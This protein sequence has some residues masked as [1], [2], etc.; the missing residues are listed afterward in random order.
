MPQ[1][2]VSPS[3]PALRQIQAL[4]G[5]QAAHSHFARPT[6]GKSRIT[7]GDNM[8]SSSRNMSAQ[9][10]CNAQYCSRAA[11]DIALVAAAFTPAFA[12]AFAPALSR[13]PPPPAPA[14]AA[15]VMSDQPSQSSP[16]SDPD[17]ISAAPNRIRYADDVEA[18]RRRSLRRRASN[19]SDLS[20]R[21]SRSFARR[22]VEPAVVLPIEFRTLSF[23]V[24]QT[25]A[26]A[27]EDLELKE[28]EKAKSP[29]KKLDA[30]FDYATVDWHKLTVHDLCIRLSTSLQ[31]GLSADVAARKLKEYG[32]NAPSPPPS[33]WFRRSVGYF[34]GGFG[35][36]LLTASILVFIAWKPLGD[37]PAQAN[38]ALA[39]VLLVVFFINAAFNLYQDWSSSRV[40]SSIKTM[41]PEECLLLRDGIKQHHQGVDIVPGDVLYLRMGDKLPA[42]VRFVE[43]S[44]DAKF[45]RSI[46]TGETAP[47][48]GTVDS[49]DENFLETACIGMAGTHIVSGS[50]VGVVIGTGDHSV[51]G[52]LAKLT[53]APKT[54]LTGLEK[55]IYYFVAMIVCIM[56]T[57]VIIVISVWAGW[58]RRDHPHWIN[59]SQLIVD[60]VSVAVAFIPEGLPIAVTASLTIVAS[61]MRKNAIL[62]KS[63]KT[64]ETL[65]SVSV[66]CSDKT[67]TLTKNQMRVT[68][69]LVGRDVLTATEAAGKVQ[70][71][72]VS[73]N[74][75]EPSL[76]CKQ[77]AVVGSVCNAGEFDASTMNKP[78]SERKINGDATDTAVLRFSEGLL[79]VHETRQKWRN[80]YR[81]AFNSKNKFMIQVAQRDVY[82]PANDALFDNDN[83]R[84]EDQVLMIK[85]APDILLPRCT[86]FMDYEGHA[87]PLTESDRCFLE[88][89][90]NVY[91][92]QGKRVILLAQKVLPKHVSGISNESA[93]YENAI[94]D[95]ASR[96]FLLIGLVA[97]VDPP[98]DEIPEVVK[99]LRGAGIKIFMVT[100]DF[101]LT[102][103]AIAADCG[104]ITNP[105][106]DIHDIHSLS[107]E[108][109]SPPDEKSVEISIPTST[110]LGAPRSLVISGGDMNALTHEQWDALCKYD[111]IVFARTTPE[112]KLKIVMELQARHETVGMTGDGVNDAPSL[113]QADIGIAMG[114]GSDIAI[115]AADMVLLESFAAVVEAVK[116]GRVVF[117]NL[118]KTICYLIPAGTFSEFW[119]IMTN[120]LFGLPQV[121]SS[122]LMIIICCFTDCAAATAIAYEKPEADV[123]RQRPR[124]PRKDRLVDWKLMLHAYGTIGVMQSVSSFAMAYWYC[125]R[126]GLPFSTLWFGFGAVPEGMSQER[127]QQILNHASSIYFVNLV[128]MQWFNLMAV[129][130]RRLSLLQHPPLWVKETRNLWLFPAILFS[131][132]IAFLFLYPKQLQEVLSTTSVPVAHWFL[133]MAF[134][135][136]ILLLDEA[137]KWAARKWPRGWVA[138][139]AW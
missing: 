84:P 113:K 98:R 30:E 123:L 17:L 66:I 4:C 5:G 27:V 115:E 107:T 106:E 137:R 99:T 35:S 110:A 53:S 88:D 132:G 57:M 15:A 45:D 40:M 96:G 65:G 90:K 101:Q 44:P 67:G 129:R 97:I 85:G 36:I 63:L 59:V 133:P 9:S 42:D 26:K 92:K 103:A 20:T 108:Y 71:S 7:G 89:A 128:V 72:R 37:P 117:D 122:F 83:P 64:V 16:D 80:V 32:P 91:S 136:G 38:L 46:L 51:F 118:K 41:L 126:Q 79:S 70:L 47:L 25:Q 139:V 105:P 43:V 48:R 61:I 73:A 111:E 6:T 52:R 60:C 124:N 54:G 78:L 12:P 127:S 8:A 130:T 13:H 100:G 21:T 3:M 2:A 49:T 112:Q 55:E 18:L 125:Q 134:G 28:K 104:I 93:Q 33:T 31:H 131:L 62:C 77:L 87:Q 23:N 75:A 69:C 58:L 121:L 34:F 19:A 116:Y 14:R 74:I 109:A 135:M 10:E 82:E 94:M 120:V 114:G 22:E 86:R 68:D 119:P 81:V 39:T 102:A 1:L 29:K 50:A 95:E 11:R 56:L 76:A 24:E 138:K